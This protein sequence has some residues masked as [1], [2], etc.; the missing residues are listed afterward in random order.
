MLENILRILNEKNI[1]KIQK[2]FVKSFD[3]SE[4][5]VKILFFTQNEAFIS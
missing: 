2:N 4:F 3:L 5:E 1:V